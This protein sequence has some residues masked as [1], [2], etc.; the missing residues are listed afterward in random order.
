MTRTGIFTQS[1]ESVLQDVD[2]FYFGGALPWFHGTEL[3][4]ADSKI[5]V[6]L[7]DPEQDEG[8]SKAYDLTAT[9]IKN[10][11]Q[12]AKLNGYRLCCVDDIQNERLGYGCVQDLDIILQTACYGRLIFG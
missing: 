9:Q 1:A 8:I 2:E 11:F 10:A 3:I 7:D 6:H 5:R 12:A 4:P